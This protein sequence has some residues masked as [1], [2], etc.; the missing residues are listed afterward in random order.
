MKVAEIYTSGEY[1]EKNPT[2]HVERSPWKAK[3]IMRMVARS[4]I[5]PK[6]ICEVGCGAGE[7]LKQLQGEMD[8]ACSFWGYEI[9]PQAI[10]LAK[11][12]EN[13]RLHFK[14]ADIT[15]EDVSFDLILIMDVIE[16]IED[17]FSFLRTLKA[18]SE[19]KIIQFV[20]DLSVVSL[21][22]PNDLQGFRNTRGH[23]GHVH[24]FTKN[25]ALGMLED[26]GYEVLDYFYTPRSIIQATTIGKKI[27]NLPRSL[28]FSIRKDLAVR[29]LGGYGLMVLV[30]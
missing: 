9:S 12:R 13:E 7:I 28:F 26:L 20:L 17:C 11:S 10:E 21:V 14:L 1:L 6:T 24:Y 8:P 16:H 15:Q 25:I 23:V 22:R 29:V 3:Q 4:D 27:L 19:Y 5:T 2:W 18:K 30:K